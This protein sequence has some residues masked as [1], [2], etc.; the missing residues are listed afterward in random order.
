MGLLLVEEIKD[1]LSDSS[2]VALNRKLIPLKNKIELRIQS[3]KQIYP[4]YVK[5]KMITFN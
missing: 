3:L 2:R 1:Y 5:K 4:F